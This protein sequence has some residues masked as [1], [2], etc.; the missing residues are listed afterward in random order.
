MKTIRLSINYFQKSGSHLIR[1][2]PYG[3]DHHHLED[4][5]LVGGFENN[6]IM[7]F[8]KDREGMINNLS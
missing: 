5:A 3:Q 4:W 6:S 8:N 1:F 7:T 2:L